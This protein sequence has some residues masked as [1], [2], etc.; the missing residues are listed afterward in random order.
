MQS[1]SETISQ[2]DELTNDKNN[3]VNLLKGMF[4]PKQASSELTNLSPHKT[5][6]KQVGMIGNLMSRFFA[7]G[8]YLELIRLLKKTNGVIAGSAALWLASPFCEASQFNGDIDIWIQDVSGLM[9]NHDLPKDKGYR[10][11]KDDGYHSRERKILVEYVDSVMRQMGYS[12][13]MPISFKEE[14]DEYDVEVDENFKH[15]NTI[16]TYAPNNSN[17]YNKNVQRIQVIYTNIP[18]T[19][20]VGKFDFTICQ[21]YWD[22]NDLYSYYPEHVNKRVF[23][24]LSPESANKKLREAK[25]TLRGFVAI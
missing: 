15:I 12:R 4:P 9:R 10:L 18:S 1:N 16:H 20:M 21:T 2:V 5:V 11:Y 19:E 7:D 6:I 3:L 22:G 23:K 8:N 17:R 13:R 14:R 24:N 25:Y